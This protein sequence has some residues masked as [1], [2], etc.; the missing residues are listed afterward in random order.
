MLA[1]RWIVV[2]A[3]LVAKGP[4]S[5]FAAEQSPLALRGPEMSLEISLDV[6]D[7]TLG[8]I[9]AALG[10]RS[11]AEF[12]ISSE[13][14]ALRA[15]LSVEHVPLRSILEL[16]AKNLQL[17]YVAEADG[18][19][20]ERRPR[21]DPRAPNYAFAFETVARTDSAMAAPGTACRPLRRPAATSQGCGG[22][23]APSRGA[24]RRAEGWRGPAHRG[25]LHRG[26]VVRPG[27]LPPRRDARRGLGGWLRRADRAEARPEGHGGRR[28]G[29]RGVCE[30]GW[31]HRRFGDQPGPIHGALRPTLTRGNVRRRRRRQA[32]SFP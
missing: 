2:T 5:G 13:V 27:H 29:F 28:Q 15:S 8:R 31:P 6:Q 22:L 20:V 21:D 1:F 25:L 14:S 16:L 12:G 19:R 18:V 26:R 11:G 3:L 32:P 23:L 4:V 7:E 24:S 30:R 17:V 9:F 10:E